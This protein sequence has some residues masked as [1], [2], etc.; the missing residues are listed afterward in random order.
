MVPY[1]SNKARRGEK[2]VWVT[3][4]QFQIGY[5]GLLTLM[6][7]TGEYLSITVEAVFPSDFFVR[8]ISEAG[9]HLEHRPDYD[10]DRTDGTKLTKVYA[11]LRFKDGGHQLAVMCR[12]EVESIRQRSKAKDAPAWADSWVEMAKKTVLR[13]A[14]KYAP[15]STELA[16]VLDHEDEI[17]RKATIVSA[18]PDVLD[19]LSRLASQA[20]DGHA[21]EPPQ[22]EPTKPE[23]KPEPPPPPVVDAVAL[24]AHDD[25]VSELNSLAQAQQMAPMAMVQAIAR[26][27]KAASVPISVKLTGQSVDLGGV[28]DAVLASVV[29]SLRP[30]Q[31]RRRASDPGMDG[32]GCGGA[33]ADSVRRVAEPR[34]AVAVAD[35]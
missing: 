29:A 13:R 6:R 5:G 18:V 3:E 12:N 26:A 19:G 15:K 31:S 7:R 10:I 34:A 27:Q 2:P 14:A 32:R 28:S 17:E 22:L 33:A 35:R 11:V 20:G 30:A 24:P 23:P 8:T 16:D 25:L 4:A 9:E 21:S 1:N